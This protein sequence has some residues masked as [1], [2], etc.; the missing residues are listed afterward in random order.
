MHEP[1]AGLDSDAELKALRRENSE[2]RRV[3]AI[4]KTASAF[5]RRVDPICTV[6]R[7]H[8]IKIATSTYYAAKK[9]G[10]VSA[11]ALDAAYAA[12]NVHRLY[13]ANRRLYGIG[14][15]GMRGNA[16][17]TVSAAI[18]LAGCGAV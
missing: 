6:L 3:K 7:E 8:R 11:A 14:N 10:K 2:L 12:N 16:P 5:S 18:K 4:L 17:A 1:Q 13:L 9:R 15:C